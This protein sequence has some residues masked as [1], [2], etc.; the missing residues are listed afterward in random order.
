MG[1]TYRMEL[2]H[3]CNRGIDGRHLFLDSQDYARFVHELY[4]FNDTKPAD[5]LHRL[6]NLGMKDLGGLSFQRTRERLVDIHGWCLMKDHYHLLLSE[7][8]DDGLLRFMT[9]VNVGVYWDSSCTNA[10]SSIIIVGAL[11]QIVSGSFLVILLA[12][13]SVLMAS[14][15]IFG[16]FLVTRRML[17]MFQRS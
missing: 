11:L 3:V 2:Y 17:A 5:N 4:E 6:F 1:Y 7:L 14:V 8:I 15:N 10:I 12:A 13:V 16:G 9:K